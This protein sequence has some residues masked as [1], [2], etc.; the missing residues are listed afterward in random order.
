[1]KKFKKVMSLFTA[2]VIAVTAL[3]AVS[4]SAS[5]KKSPGR[6]YTKVYKETCEDALIL[7]IDGI[8]E[9]MLKYI[10][11][12][13]HS[14]PVESMKLF[15]TTFTVVTEDYPT[16][17]FGYSFDMTIYPTLT[18]ETFELNFYKKAYNSRAVSNVPKNRIRV[19]YYSNTIKGLTSGYMITVSDANV[20][21]DFSQD[22][23]TDQLAF[24][25]LP[26]ETVANSGWQYKTW[27]KIEDYDTAIDPINTGLIEK[28]KIKKPEA[29]TLSITKKGTK[30]TFKWDAVE[31][32]D[33]FQI[34]YSAGGG[35]YNKLY[36]VSPTKTSLIKK[37]ELSGK[38]RFRIR[39]YKV[40][41][42]K[43]YYSDWSNTVVV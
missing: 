7:F 26:L 20:A 42:G 31:G 23:V 2:V 19:E 34:Y 13:L 35:N 6:I 27:G 24:G 22:L 28:E 4:V 25:G 39:S 3:F 16:A 14:L 36:T 12:D 18:N 33:K 1:M 5:A 30:Y 40:I 21:A 29:T 37:I 17:G 11:R 41:N 15:R 38:Y 32:V 10:S 9:A 8:D 43:K